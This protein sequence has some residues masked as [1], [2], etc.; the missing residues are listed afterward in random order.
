MQDF[1]KTCNIT[2]DSKFKFDARE[3]WKLFCKTIA[4]TNFTGMIAKINDALISKSC[5]Y[6]NG[7]HF[8]KENIVKL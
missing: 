2:L 5:Y 4:S 3:Q 7:T 8:S 6:D 1:I